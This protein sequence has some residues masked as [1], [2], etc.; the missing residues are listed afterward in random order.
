M[1]GLSWQIYMPVSLS[2]E[3]SRDPPFVNH[4]NNIVI[5]KASY[6]RPRRSKNKPP[7]GTIKVVNLSLDGLDVSM[8]IEDS[9]RV[10]LC[11][12]RLQ[13]RI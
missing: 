3:I 11:E 7:C 13:F 4:I 1:A 12:P 2:R 6:F 5:P 8:P 10:V 9:G